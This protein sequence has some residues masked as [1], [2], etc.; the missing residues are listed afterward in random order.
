MI[1]YLT[2]IVFLLLS[3]CCKEGIEINK[4]VLSE[5][6]KACIP[7]FNNETIGFSH[8]N[9]FEF[10]LN[11]T[12]RRTELRK[13]DIHHC[14]D[15]YS[16]YEILTAELFSTI[17]ELFINVEIA[18]KEFNPHMTIS[19]NKYNFIVDITS[20]PDIDTLT[21]NG[22]KFNNIYQADYHTF[23]TLI[24]QPKQVL[25]NK[26]VGIIQII[27]TNNETFTVDK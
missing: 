15:N 12:S 14:G 8:T 2:I 27:M 24:I 17:P 25:Y 13:T 3:S 1:K 19:I 5:N 22:N 9:G 20:K 10:D 6:E 26:E 7:Y 18:A 23:D 21:I 11:V 16:T 4:Y